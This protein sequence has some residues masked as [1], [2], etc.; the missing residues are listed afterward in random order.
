SVYILQVLSLG[1][2]GGLLG[3]AMARGVIAAI[4]LA[5]GA[6]TSLLAQ[7]HYGVTWSAALQGTGV[8]VLVSLLFS[9]VPLLQVRVI[10]PSL[11]LCAGP[12]RRRRDVL[13]G[14]ALV[15]VLAALV[16][17]TSWQAAS[18]RVGLVV[19]A[20]FAGRAVVIHSSGR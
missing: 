18:L 10:K 6:S 20:G 3:V 12:V 13:S 5:I 1:L 9:I 8:G 14:V 15:V 4:P 16:A 17:L 11:L 2:A 7:A 19:C